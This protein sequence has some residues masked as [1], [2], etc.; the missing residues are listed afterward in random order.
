MSIAG[1][2]IAALL[3]AA[4]TAFIIFRRVAAARAGRRP[5]PRPAMGITRNAADAWNASV[6]MF[7]GEC[8]SAEVQLFI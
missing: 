8:G 3:V 4:I 7:A 1:D 5:P 6:Q 2:V